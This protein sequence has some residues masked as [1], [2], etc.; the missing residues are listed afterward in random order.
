MK[1]VKIYLDDFRTPTDKEWIVTRDYN[2]F[3]DTVNYHG[4]ENIEYISLDHDLDET[5]MQE[6][7]NNV[8]PNYT[9][10][11]ENIKQP[12]GLHAAMFLIEKFYEENQSRTLMS[13]SERKQTTFHFP[14]VWVHSANPIGSANIMG[15]MNNFY[16]NEGEAQTCI[17][18][19]IEHERE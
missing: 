12:T 10:N 11:Y 15:Y 6:Y 9:L 17:R 2:Q 1:K 13:R 3:V 18:V 16:M 8:S 5:A 7:F 4:L 14:T 19:M